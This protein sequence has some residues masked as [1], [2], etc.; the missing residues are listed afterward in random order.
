[1][2]PRLKKLRKVLNPPLIKG[3]KPYGPEVGLLNAEPILLHYEEYEA[4]R[5]CDYDMYNHHEASVIMGVSRP[6]FTRIYASVRQKVAMAFAEGRQMA[7]EGGKVYFDSDWYSCESCKC[8]FNNPHKEI[9]IKE[10]PLCGSKS[11][12]DFN[13]DEES[14]SKPAGKNCNDIC[15][16]P[17][18]GYEEGHKLGK[19]C[20][21]M[22]CPK[23]NAKMRRKNNRN[24]NKNC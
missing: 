11:I 7:I 17:S 1:M 8:F 14:D 15:F 9:E 10:C 6:T 21:Q 23:C 2:S 13:V 18:C 5:L 12:N 24:R 4:L 22:V 3:F 20:S 19:P 16:C